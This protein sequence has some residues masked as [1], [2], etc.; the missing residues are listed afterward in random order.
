MDD[1]HFAAIGGIP[2]N[3]AAP[4]TPGDKPVIEELVGQE[5]KCDYM[6]DEGMHESLP[7]VSIQSATRR[8]SL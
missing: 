5:V 3:K 7:S 2:H 8:A 1:V 6:R 4:I